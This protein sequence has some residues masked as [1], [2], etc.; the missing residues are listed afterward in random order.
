MLPPEQNLVPADR[1]VLTVGAWA[2]RGA[3]AN[4][5]AAVET[6]ETPFLDTWAMVRRRKGLLLFGLV[7]GVG[8]AYLYY[9]HATP[10]FETQVQILVMP[11]DAQVPSSKGDLQSEH[12]YL[13]D[14]LLQTHA[15]LIQSRRLVKAAVEK[16]H[17]ETLPSFARQ[18]GLDVA[19]MIMA[20]LDVGK[21]GKTTNRDAHVLRVTYRSAHPEDCAPVLNALVESYQDF[22][23]RTFKDTSV[24]AVNLI[25]QA[26]HDL[27]DELR[28]GEQ[29]YREFREQSPLMI[30]NRDT[31]NLPAQRLVEIDHLLMA[32]KS[33]Y[34]EVSAQL[35]VVEDA[36]RNPQQFKNFDDLQ[37]L[38]VLG[39]KD[40]TR[41]NTLMNLLGKGTGAQ[42]EMGFN[43]Q[44]TRQQLIHIQYDQVLQL[45]LHER[46]LRQTF[47]PEHPE[48]RAITD[49][50]QILE[51][52]LKA[53]TP[54]SL[55]SGKSIIEPTDLLKIVLQSLRHEKAQLENRQRELEAQ[56]QQEEAAAKRLNS[57][58]IQA[59]TMRTALTRKN[60]LYNAVIERL[61]EINLIKDYGGFVT[62]VITPVEVPTTPVA[63]KL[64]FILGIGIALGL[65]GG[66]GLA[67]LADAADRTFHSPDEVRSTLRLPIM[68]T[69]PSFVGRKSKSLTGPNGQI[70]KVDPLLVAFHRP[71]SFEAETFR[72]LRTALYFS[73][74][75]RRRKVI[76]VSSPSAG[77]GKTT[78]AAN[79]AVS[80]AQSGKKVL[81]VDADF[82]R[83]KVHKLFGIEAQVGLAQVL[84]DELELGDTVQATE[85]ANLW[86][87]PTG[88]HPTNPSELLSSRKFEDLI[89]VVREKYDFVVIDTPP[90]LAVS[91]AAVVAPRMDGVL[92]TLRI[93]KNGRPQAVRARQILSVLGVQ[94]LGVVVNGLNPD[95]NYGY[96][97]SGRY[98][99][100]DGYY[101]G[102]DYDY[103]VRKVN[104][105]GGPK[106]SENAPAPS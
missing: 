68:T 66:V 87:L 16:R 18:D 65:L 90:I 29:A 34:A 8:L 27:E 30:G 44:Q 4:T 101:A 13:D 85:V 71:D 36:L 70:S 21:G 96:G 40:I 45:Q 42:S 88:P 50:L 11:K 22:L 89:A 26:K 15:L 80:M 52:F 76:Q 57:Y 93:T 9:E 7:V 69:I 37:R 31:T 24:E 82:R 60:D 99:Y 100:G 46:V 59:E 98:Y 47:G 78:M 62:E 19:G 94:V 55:L 5:E 53:N 63:P 72:N 14:R 48:V 2:N 33:Q 91:D 32:A 23:G 38:T 3:P 79:L 92:L 1:N 56:A 77:D 43:Y 73:T 12:R 106:A 54:G 10:V 75:G 104:Y 28:A 51:E 41:L 86:V 20:Q 6:R 105:D 49:Q 95:R 67:Y 102:G 25:T 17:L 64:N 39:E 97:Y 74:Y 81:L 35:L 83:A 58:D 103:M 84:T 61:R